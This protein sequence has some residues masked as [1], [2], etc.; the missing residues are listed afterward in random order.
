MTKSSAAYQDSLRMIKAYFQRFRPKHRDVNLGN[1]WKP[2][3][4]NKF[5]NNKVR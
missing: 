4:I 3:K 2:D 5:L 1:H